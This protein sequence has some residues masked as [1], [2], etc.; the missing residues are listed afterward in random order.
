MDMRRITSVSLFFFWISFPIIANSQGCTK[1]CVQKLNDFSGGLS[2]KL[3]A[4][5]IPPKQGD[6]V[7]NIRFDTELGS[8]TKRDGLFTACDA[9][10][11]D[12]ILGLHRLYLADGTK[13]TLLNYAN[14][15]ATCNE[16]TGATTTILTLSSSDQR[17]KWLTWHDI[18]IGTDGTNAMV[19]Y[20]GTSTSAT[21]VGSAL[22][23]D[24]GAGA[25]PNGTYTYKIACYTTSYTV[26]LDT[27][28]NSVTVTDND[29][30]LSMIPICPD[31]F[32]GESV[33]GRKVYRI[34]N[35]GSTYKLLTNGTIANNT[36]TTLTD[37]DADAALGATLSATHTRQPPKGRVH[38]V[39]RNRLWVANNSSNKS[40]LFYGADASNDFFDSPAE[41]TGGY[42]DVRP[43]DGD[44]ITMLMN[45]LGKMV[46]GKNNSIQLLNAD[47]DTPSEDWAISDPYSFIGNQAI[48]SPA[49]TPI[50]IIYLANNGLYVFNN[51]YSQLISD[52]VTPE[53]RDIQPSNFANVWGA[54]FKNSYYL[55]YTSKATG[56]STNDRVLIFDLLSKAYAKDLMDINVFGVF[57]SGT[58]VEALYSGSSEESVIYSHAESNREIVHKVHDDFTGTFDDM[59]YIP[60]SVG[61]DANSPVLEIAWTET[62]DQMTGTIDAAS[63]IIDR[64]DTDGFYISQYLTVN[65]N[66]F[67]K[68]YWNEVIPSG[69]GDVTFAI[70]AGAT[71]PDTAAAAW[72]SE[73]STSSGSDISGVTAND[74]MQYRATMDTSDITQTPNLV[75]ANNYVVKITYQ[76]SGDAAET[77]I[78]LLWRSGWLDFGLPLYIKQLRTMHVLYE[79]QENTAGTLNVDFENYNGDTDSFDIDL[80][81]YPD[82]YKEQFSGGS[83][84]GELFRIQISETSLNPIR[85]REIILVYDVAPLSFRPVP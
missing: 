84:S 36:A 46:V 64:P 68:I 62:I 25:G 35:G 71:T 58:D 60:V 69:G 9:T 27:A 14:K 73:F 59:R 50:G 31:T 82:Q 11:A 39:H 61:G 72:S 10:T 43:N 66:E 23:K 21:Y 45:N 52:V 70:R 28:S 2:T 16:S 6:I 55:A 29:I 20:D 7:E 81:E 5:S 24:N 33:T 54:Y 53:I 3:S 63:G 17:M 79:W 83:F 41:T 47:G 74:Y 32:N 38:L 76:V 26:S 8:L 57:N 67:D 56:S 78:P 18:A 44:E 4:L 75:R 12:P 65:A 49:N 19:K 37:S 48:Y 42:F 85:I 1:N 40:R 15:I 34:E 77:T 80:L 51:Q 13:V 30:D 22:A